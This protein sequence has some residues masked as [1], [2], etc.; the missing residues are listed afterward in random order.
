[1]LQL[2]N[3]VEIIQIQNYKTNVPNTITM[4]TKFLTLVLQ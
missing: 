2:C 1:M 3:I 4:L